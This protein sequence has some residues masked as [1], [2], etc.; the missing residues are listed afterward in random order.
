MAEVKLE[1]R[2]YDY[3]SGIFKKLSTTGVSA[4]AKLRSSAD[5]LKKSIFSLKG[6]V[7]GLG[8]TILAKSFIDVASTTE[9]FRIRLNAL[10]G[11]VEEGNRLFQ[12]MTKFASQ[13]PFEYKEIMESATA[14][15]GVMEGGVD[16]IVKWMPMIADLAAV[17]G[18]SIQETTSQVIRM[19]SAGAAAADMFRERGILAMLGFQA[20]VSY[21]VEETRR[22]M[23]ESIE[24]KFKGASQKLAKTWE[25][26]M[27]MLKDKWFQ[28]RDAVMN[29]APYDFMKSALDLLNKELDTF[30]N[31]SESAANSGNTLAEVIG[32]KIVSAMET[33]IKAVG[34]VYDAFTGLQMLWN[35]LKTAFLEWADFVWSNLHKIREGVTS[36]WEKIN[37]KGIFDEQVKRSK[38]ISMEQ[39]QIITSIRAALVDAR[40]EYIELLKKPS[41]LEQANKLIKAIE[42]NMRNVKTTAAETKSE[43]T[44]TYEEMKARF[45][46]M[47]YE[48]AKKKKLTVDTEEAVTSVQ[49]VKSAIDAIPDVTTKTVIIETYT[50]SS[51][52]RPFSEG[53]EY[54]KNKIKS[55]S[56]SLQTTFDLSSMSKFIDAAIQAISSIGAYIYKGEVLADPGLIFKKMDALRE[57]GFPVTRTFDL[58]LGVVGP[59]FFRKPRYSW[60]V[61]RLIRNYLSS[62]MILG[63]FQ[64]GTSYV[65]AT[66]LYL[67]HQGEAVIPASQNRYDNR[68]YSQVNNFYIQGSSPQEIAQEID[69]ILAKQARYNRSQF[70]RVLKNA[71]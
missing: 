27:T 64:T 37:I 19:Y 18:L 32:Q 36:I 57:M 12:E 58:G 42:E 24:S 38:E 43:V 6:A 22:K 50:K 10:L 66:G 4:F 65:P 44:M 3:A 17:S 52:L 29:S 8:T 45:I 31:K 67:L 68:Q 46:E 54:M 61:D 69:R 71:H 23:L 60:E 55:L 1:V 59:F 41:G 28:F 20:G 56:Q 34:G 15:A 9:S 62:P 51:P 11:S 63:S 33:S 26:L 16:E 21:T 40:K 13:V 5:S 53:I 30:K 7:A 70:T 48:L 2:A 39:L 49:K 25:G 14:L 35:K 47:N